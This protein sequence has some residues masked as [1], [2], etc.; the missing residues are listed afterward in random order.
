MF[1]RMKG[2]WRGYRLLRRG[3]AELAGIRRALEVLADVHLQAAAQ[4][5]PP[6]RPPTVEDATVD[7]P[8]VET[9]QQTALM[10]I[11]LR[12]TQARG[13]PPTEEEVLTEFERRYGQPP[14]GQA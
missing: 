3:V 7:A 6:V 10:D 12:L 8:Y 1:S 5:Q 14:A 13:V 11:E 2:L 4:A 9:Y